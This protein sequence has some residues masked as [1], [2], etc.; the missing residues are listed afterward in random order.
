MIREFDTVALTKAL[1]EHGLEADDLGTV[2]MVHRDGAGFEVEFVTLSGETVAVE[3]LP[4]DA[5]RE[6][7]PD[8]IA[9]ARAMASP[10]A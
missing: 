7:R 4:A 8:E 9:N 10:R 6:L 2:A 5:V 1:P 3:T